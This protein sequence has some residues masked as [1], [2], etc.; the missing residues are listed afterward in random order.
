MYLNETWWLIEN[1]EGYLTIHNI[2]SDGDVYGQRYMC[3]QLNKLFIVSIKSELWFK[4]TNQHE[5][6]FL[7][8]RTWL[9]LIISLRT[10]FI[11]NYDRNIFFAN[12]IVAIHTSN[13]IWTWKRE[14]EKYKSRNIKGDCYSHMISFTIEQIIQNFF[15]QRLS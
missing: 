4:A 10:C 8:V 3:I 13:D 14:K 2:Q 9:F 5:M 12:F 15:L 7:L 1:F 11:I 6:L